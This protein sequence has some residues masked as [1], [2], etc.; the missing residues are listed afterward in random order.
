MAGNG[1]LRLDL[2]RTLAAVASRLDPHPPPATRAAGEGQ[3]PCGRGA[4]TPRPPTNSTP[5]G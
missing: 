3:D 1:R 2:G 5:E 4:L